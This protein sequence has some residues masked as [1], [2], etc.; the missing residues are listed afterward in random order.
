[1]EAEIR[2]IAGEKPY[3]LDLA[4]TSRTG[5]FVSLNLTLEVCDEVERLAIYDR[6]TKSQVIMQV[7]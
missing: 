1:M 3:H 4:N 7:L 2:E 5:K 6:L